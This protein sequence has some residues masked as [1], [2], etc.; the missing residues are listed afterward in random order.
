MGPR[1]VQ[2]GEKKGTKRA[3]MLRSLL[4]PNLE[5]TWGR[6]GVDFGVVLESI[7]RCFRSVFLFLFPLL[8]FKFF[9]ESCLFLRFFSL[10]WLAWPAMSPLALPPFFSVF[11]SSSFV[12]THF[13]P[14]S[15]VEAARAARAAEHHFTWLYHVHHCGSG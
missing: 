7:L 1:G 13:Y 2:K 15:V 5:P 8:F 6:F 3:S 10:A 14:V 9:F 11:L 12:F 4:G